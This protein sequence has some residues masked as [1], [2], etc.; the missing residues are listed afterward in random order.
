MYYV[1]LIKYSKHP[2]KSG[3]TNLVPFAGHK[4][5]CTCHSISTYFRYRHKLIR[6]DYPEFYMLRS[7]MLLLVH[8]SVIV[9]HK[10]AVGYFG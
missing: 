10:V 1:M 9:K 4:N 6:S 3:G 7:A 5:A 8:G 2:I